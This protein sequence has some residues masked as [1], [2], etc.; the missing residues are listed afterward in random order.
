MIPFGPRPLLFGTP[1]HPDAGRDFIFKLSFFYH[2]ALFIS[3]MPD[4]HLEP[5]HNHA[6][7][8]DTCMVAFFS[9]FSVFIL[10]YH[11]SAVPVTISSPV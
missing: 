7:G 11:A 10:F 9:S 4:L 5:L 1:L 3:V 6:L 2:V 8:I